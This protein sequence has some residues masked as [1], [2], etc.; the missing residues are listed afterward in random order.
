VTQFGLSFHQA[1]IL[2]RAWI[3]EG[4]CE[5]VLVGSVEECGT[6][7]EYICSRRLGIAEDGRISPFEFSPS[8]LA[9]PGEGS[10]FLL[11]TGEE[12]DEKYCELR[13]VFLDDESGEGEPDL[14]I[15]DA[16]GMSEDETCYQEIAGQDVLI[17]AYS[18]L[19]GS[20][21]TGSAFHCAVAAVM[22]R[23][24]TLYACPVQ[25]NPHAV[26]VCTSTEEK[27]LERVQCVRYSC[28][29]ERAVIELGR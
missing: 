8:P 17:G 5:Q 22:L 12:R 18:P 27:K 3:H 11:L 23:N 21:L 1:L 24:Q 19:L 6:V 16:D 26:P 4:R 13:G 9:V 25:E 15:L 29:R 7:M 20:M 14:R 2:A 28:L 10:V